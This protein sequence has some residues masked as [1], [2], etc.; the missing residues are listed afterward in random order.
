MPARDP[1]HRVLTGKIRQALKAVQA[2]NIALVEPDVITAD[3]LNLEYEVNEVP[4]ILAEL[5][6]QVTPDHYAGTRPPQRSYET[7][8]LGCELYAFK[9]ESKRLGCVI[10]FKFALK[11]DFLWV[12]SIHED[13]PARETN[14]E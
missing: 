1:T 3:L 7:D 12:V 5:L 9:V 13:R 10:Y 8:L 14:R 6:K 11:E 4:E 2:G